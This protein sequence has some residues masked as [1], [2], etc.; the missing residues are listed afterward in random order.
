[1]M[2]EYIFESINFEIIQ[3]NC[4]QLQHIMVVNAPI[5]PKCQWTM[6]TFRENR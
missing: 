6:Q 2:T 3:M 5:Q 4:A 1:M